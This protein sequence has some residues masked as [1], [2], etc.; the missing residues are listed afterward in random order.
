MGGHRRPDHVNLAEPIVV[1]AAYTLLQ[2]CRR[3]DARQTAG[4]D[5]AASQPGT[6]T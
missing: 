6:A 1:P 2:R 5:L 4:A 3:L